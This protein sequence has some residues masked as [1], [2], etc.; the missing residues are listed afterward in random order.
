MAIQ[1]LLPLLHQLSRT[2][3]LRVLQYIANDLAAEEGITPMFDTIEALRSSA[4]AARQLQALLE[5]E[6]QKTRE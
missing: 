4:E 5:A 6:E 1:E 3:K 2:D